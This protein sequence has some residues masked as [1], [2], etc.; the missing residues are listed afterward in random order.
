M[1][2]THKRSLKAKRRK[3]AKAKLKNTRR[4]TL[5]RLGRPEPVVPSMRV[6]SIRERVYQPF[7]DSLVRSSTAPAIDD[8]QPLFPGLSLP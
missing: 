8:S 1:K 7:Y 6:T 5:N 3:R 4:A 2:S